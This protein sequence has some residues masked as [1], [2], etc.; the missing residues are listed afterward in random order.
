MSMDFIH[1]FAGLAHWGE[2]R[3]EKTAIQRARLWA[4]GMAVWKYGH[5]AWAASVGSVVSGE[6]VSKGSVGLFARSR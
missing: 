2:K 4:L 6:T 5:A 3:A 1:N